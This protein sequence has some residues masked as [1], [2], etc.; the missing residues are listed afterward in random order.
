VFSLGTGTEYTAL[1]VVLMEGRGWVGSMV[2]TWNG[3]RPARRFDNDGA[4]VHARWL[5]P[6]HHQWRVILDTDGVGADRGG[7]AM[8]DDGALMITK[9]VKATMRI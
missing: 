1:G 2:G 9:G 4:G 6:Q 5:R 8:L 3:V 7:P